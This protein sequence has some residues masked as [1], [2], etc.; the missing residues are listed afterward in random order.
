MNKS[1][2]NL[3]LI[4]SVIYSAASFSASADATKNITQQEVQEMNLVKNGSVS[5]SGVR[6]G[7]EDAIKALE[8][9][10]SREGGKLYSITS[11]D[12]PGDSTMWRGSA[13]YY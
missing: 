4:A 2:K 3:I 5:V 11:L 8:K 10:V 1:F 9:K 12:T 7:P 6:G 13:V